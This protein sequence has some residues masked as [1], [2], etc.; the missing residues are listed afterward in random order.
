VVE[1]VARGLKVVPGRKAAVAVLA[2]YQ[3]CAR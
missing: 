1:A 3:I 2:S